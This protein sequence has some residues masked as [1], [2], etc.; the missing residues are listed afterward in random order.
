MSVYLSFFLAWLAV[1]S[2]SFPKKRR[3]PQER[4]GYL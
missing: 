3:D 1:L 4:T 2:L